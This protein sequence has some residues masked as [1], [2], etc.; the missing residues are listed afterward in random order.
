MAAL[1]RIEDVKREG[2]HVDVDLLAK[3][4]FES[5]SEADRY[6]L[7]T[8]GIC[9]QRQVGVFMMRIRIP[10]GKCSAAQLRRV[11][12]LTKKYGHGTLHVTTR[13]GLEIHHV[14]I[15]DVPRVWAELSEVELTTKGTCG[16]TIRN[17]IGCSHAGSYAGEVLPIA[18]FI[19]L[20]HDRIV[21]ISD[22]TN[23]S[24]KM[25][26]AMACSPACDDHAATTDIG[27]VATPSPKGDGLPGFA[28]WGAGGLGAAPRLSILIAP[29]LPQ[30]DV[31]PAFSA[32]IA[33]GEKHG[34]RASRAKAKIKM[35]VEKWG[36]EKFIAVFEEELEAIRGRGLPAITVTP[37]APIAK[38]PAA[39]RAGSVQEQKQQ[40]F[41][42]IPALIPMGELSCAGADALADACEHFGNGIITLTPDQ[43]A[44]LQ[45]VEQKNVDRA[46]AAIEA[47]GLQTRGR[48]SIT[49]VVSCVGLEYCA[50]A[51]AGSMTLGDEIAHAMEPRRVDP[52][53]ADFRIHVSGCP[54]SCAKH[55][56]AD[57]GLSGG[58]QE[59]K[60][61]RKEVFTLFLGGN[62]AERRL[63]TTFP[64]KIE[65]TRIVPV[66]EALIEVY[67]RVAKADERFSG[68]V[69]RMGTEPFFAAVRSAMR[70]TSK[71][72]TS[73][74]L[75]VVGNGMAGMR[76]VEELRKRDKAGNF[77]ITVFG[78]E[79]GGNYNRI[80]LSGVLGGERKSDEIVTHPIAWYDEH[81][82]TL[83]A[84]NR[85]AK[86]DRARRVIVDE[87]GAEEPYDV[88]VLATGSRPFIP[89][90]E[91][92]DRPG[93]F[94]F[95]TLSDV[96]AIRDHAK[97]VKKAVVLG[98]GLLG[99]EAA[100]G[101]RAL[102]VEVTVVH[103]ASWLMEQQLD[104]DAATALQPRIEA[105][106]IDVR[107]NVRA[108]AVVGN[109]N[110]IEGVRL[111]DGQLIEGQLVIV[112][113]GITPNVEVAREGGLAI[114][115]GIIVD[116]ALRTSDEHV[117][118]LGECV[119]HRGNTY[120]LVDPLWDQAKVLA[121]LFAGEDTSYV[122]SRIGTRLKVAGV[123]VV[124]L[125]ERAPVEGDEALMSRGSDGSFRS[126]ITR[127]GMII[128]AQVVGDQDAAAKLA[129]AF[130]RNAP[131]AGDASA[132]I[133]GVR[134]AVPAKPAGDDVQREDHR[135]CVCN[136]VMESTIVCAIKEGAR[137]VASI[138]RATSAGTGCGSCRGELASLV[139]E[140]DGS[141]TKPATAH[142]GSFA[143]PATVSAV[144]PVASVAAVAAPVSVNSSLH[145]AIFAHLL[146]ELQATAGSPTA[147]R[148]YAKKVKAAA[149]L[150]EAPVT[151][152]NT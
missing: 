28:L 91:G 76:F 78:D 111:A 134:S 58:S 75:V 8:Q 72:P 14:K 116:D 103:L 52:R 126:I 1:L 7:K 33:V 44:E 93:V 64:R 59:S 87:A 104:R 65:R 30:E 128:G 84:G 136:D 71:P 110:G 88:L 140:H 145:E 25:N 39:P 36:A 16:D 67:E 74:K 109:V 54:H 53:Y 13:G 146:S 99:L 125:G 97:G 107:T 34:D 21:T 149:I 57:I 113:C 51:V 45:F 6:R 121:Q 139:M 90:I 106:G 82:V 11:S 98:G 95:R 24:R 108:T 23:I 148:S 112:C 48:G 40:G 143:K 119:Q 118:A 55:Q 135:V 81:N 18:P 12:A 131:L 4:G 62:A 32:L 3:T 141:F 102:G 80:M 15:D 17:V 138:G 152:V 56:V 63:G 43:N 29:W 47:I 68:T 151:V 19:Q 60:G 5:I 96:H 73:G 27:F 114:D 31:L 150:L 101:L 133:V 137:D 120:G 26:V 94:A 35:L 69:A 124:S 50:L 2:V 61:E 83:R 85:V 123:H 70:D 66:I 77:A 9:T 10:G 142:D 100:S 122:G 42:T 41:Y 20:L 115:R 132:F 46:V 129:Q 37:D 130:M 144:A 105:L 127:N 89:K 79:H 86:I 92:I 38:T 147:L 22:A 49:D 117:F